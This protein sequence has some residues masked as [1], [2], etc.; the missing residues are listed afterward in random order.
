IEIRDNV[1]FQQLRMNRC[2]SVS[3]VR[4]H[5]R[6]M[7]HSHFLRCSLLKQTYARNASL[8]PREA[9]TNR[10][11][12]T[13]VDLEKNFQLA[14]QHGFEPWQRPL[15]ESFGEQSMIRVSERALCD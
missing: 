2:Y 8:V 6:Y 1:V 14:W 5:H 7:R 4:A 11:E 13:V 10:L 12:K 3:A 15:L 9:L